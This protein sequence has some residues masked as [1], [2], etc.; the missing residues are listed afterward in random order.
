MVD[1]RNVPVQD[2][3]KLD[4]KIMEDAI[5]NRLDDL[6]S[7]TNDALDYPKTLNR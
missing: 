7:F 3:R 2:C 6:I 1:F 5:E 4:L